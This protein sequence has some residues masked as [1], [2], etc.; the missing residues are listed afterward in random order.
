MVTMETK[1]RLK[2]E[3]RMTEADPDTLSWPELRSA[4]LGKGH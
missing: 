4:V 1:K 3:T 2:S